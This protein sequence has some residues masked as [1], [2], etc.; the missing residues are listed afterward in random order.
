[1][2]SISNKISTFWIRQKLKD[3]REFLHETNFSDPDRLWE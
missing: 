2:A 3:F 1:M